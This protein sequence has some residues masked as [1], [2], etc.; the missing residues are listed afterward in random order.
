MRLLVVVLTVVVGVASAAAVM[1]LRHIGSSGGQATAQPTLVRPAAAQAPVPVAAGQPAAGQPAAAAV[2]CKGAKVG[3]ATDNLGLFE[4]NTKV[5]PS[6]AVKYVSWGTAFPGKAI[7]EN[8]G[9]G[10]KTQLVLEP[11][12]VKMSAIAAGRDDKFLARWAA[13]DKKLNLPMILSFAPEPN[14]SWYGW[15]EGHITPALF[16][17]AWRHIHHVLVKDGARKMTFLWQV[18]VIF[19]T[20][21]PLTELWPGAAYVGEVGID[22]HLRKGETFNSVFGPTIRQVR[23]IT[24]RPVAIGEVAVDRGTYRVRQINELF[25]GVCK[26]RL[27]RF[28]W[29]DVKRPGANF[30]L[31][32]DK[33]ALAAF[34]KDA[35]KL[36]PA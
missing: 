32:G 13:A 2:S 16:K 17:S 5:F 23:T 31:E 20:S 21:E 11:R 19:P 25:A 28:V 24:K 6:V 26:D 14:G 1:T 30:M 22:G 35:A 8:H 12:G 9:G 15:G 36:G 34:R 18:N 27:S 29:F 4:K 3:V 10:V 33:S 7:L